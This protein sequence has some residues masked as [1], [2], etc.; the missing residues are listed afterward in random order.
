MAGENVDR[1]NHRFDEWSETYERSFMQWL[2]FNNAHR[3][4]LSRLPKGFTPTYILDI[5]CGTGRLLRRMQAR[6]PDADLVGLDPSAGM[7]IRARQLTRGATIYQASA[8]HIPLGDASQ[9]LVTTTMSFHHWADQAQGVQ[10]IAR[11]LRVGGLLALADTNIGH[12]HP[13]SRRQ[14][15]YLCIACGLAIQSQS[16]VVPFLSITVGRKSDIYSG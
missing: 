4:L 5:G 3:S 9:D 11:V 7:A 1:D 12:G 10:E 8:E 2:V 16:S 13:L 15:R 6:W 14:V